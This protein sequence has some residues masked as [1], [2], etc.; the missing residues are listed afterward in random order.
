[1]GTATNSEQMAESVHEIMLNTTAYRISGLRNA[2]MM[3]LFVRMADHEPPCR[4]A[5][6]TDCCII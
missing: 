1:M 3:G 4:A 5:L 6:S 2:S